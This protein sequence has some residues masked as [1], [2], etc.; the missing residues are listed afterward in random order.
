MLMQHISKKIMKQ[1]LYIQSHTPTNINTGCYCILRTLTGQNKMLKLRQIAHG[2]QKPSFAE[3]EIKG[4][5]VE[6]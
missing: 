1:I 5:N 2:S 3:S 6:N 4:I